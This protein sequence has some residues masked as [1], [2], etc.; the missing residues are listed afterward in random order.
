[1]KKI[2]NAISIVF[3]PLF[4]PLFALPLYFS[5]DSYE[6][7]IIN[8]ANTD[9]LNA[10]YSVM[11]LVGVLF[12]LLSLYIMVRTGLVSDFNAF[13]KK[14]RAPIFI[15]VL[16]Y[17]L[18]VYF[19]YRSWNSSV[20][21]LLDPLLSFLSGGIFLIVIALI[22]NLKVKISLHCISISAFAGAFLAY[23]VTIPDIANPLFLASINVL[24]LL[25]MGFVASSR[26]YLKAH[27]PNEV[28]LGLGIGFVVELLVV[29][30]GISI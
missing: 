1:M 22:I 4:I 5:I 21:Q 25:L 9:F 13:N 29:Y 7:L 11:V 24:L 17:Y 16:I 28:Y 26:L 8:Q 27:Q 18:M 15:L 6:N 20:F 10:I 30:L 14:E 2:A 19:M 23:S 12:P 3:H